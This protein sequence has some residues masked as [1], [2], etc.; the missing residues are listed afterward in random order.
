MLKHYLLNTFN[1]KDLKDVSSEALEICRKMS[2]SPMKY[3]KEVTLVYR[4]I[5]SKGHNTTADDLLLVYNSLFYLLATEDQL[6]GKLRMV[7]IV[8][9]IWAGE[10][11]GEVGYAW[12]TWE[13]ALGMLFH[14]ASK[15]KLSELI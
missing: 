8:N 15:F 1:L 3:L 6:K 9:I 12:I 7:E 4:E 13:A 11:N 10:K 14:E 5:V 2:I